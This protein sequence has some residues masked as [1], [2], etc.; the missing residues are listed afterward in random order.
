VVV[1]GT[2]SRAANPPR[3]LERPVDVVWDAREGVVYVVD[4]GVAAGGG[5]VWRIGRLGVRGTFPPD[6]RLGSEPTPTARQSAG[7]R[8][9]AAGIAP[10]APSQRPPDDTDRLPQQPVPPHP[11]GAW[12]AE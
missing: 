5:V 8:G 11:V 12:R 3:G 1:G 4:R 7:I 6:I 2:A 10:L 9:S